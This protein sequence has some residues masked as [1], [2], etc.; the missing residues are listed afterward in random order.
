MRVAAMLGAVVAAGLL[1]GACLGLPAPFY[2]FGLIGVGEGGAMTC[3]LVLLRAELGGQLV[4]GLSYPYV[5]RELDGTWVHDPAEANLIGHVGAY[6]G[7]PRRGTPFSV[8]VVC[9]DGEQDVVGVSVFRGR[10]V[11]PQRPTG[12]YVL[13]FPPPAAGRSCL[14]PTEGSGVTLCAEVNGFVLD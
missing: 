10:L 7:G 13:N 8:R 9:L 11:A 12:L 4:G 6:T 5:G 3:Q 1:L 14:P 2:S